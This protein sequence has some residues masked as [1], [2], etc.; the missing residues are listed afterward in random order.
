MVQRKDYKTEGLRWFFCQIRN[1]LITRLLEGRNTSNKKTTP[2]NRSYSSCSYRQTATLTG[3]DGP[4][5]PKYFQHTNV[6]FLLDLFFFEFPA[7]PGP[8]KKI[9]KYQQYHF[10][11]MKNQ[12]IAIFPEIAISRSTAPGPKG[13]L[14][15][16]TSPGIIAIHR[17][18][19]PK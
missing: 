15:T 2:Q 1:S 3:S 19:S 6:D 11:Y 5:E 16:K 12:K 18:H 14:N 10:L 13:P 4:I 7:V 9:G 17:R 8:K